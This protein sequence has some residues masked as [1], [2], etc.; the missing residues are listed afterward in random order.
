VPQQAEG[1]VDGGGDGRVGV[2]GQP[3]HGKVGRAGQ[4]GEPRLEQLHARD[5]TRDVA[6]HRPDGVEAG[7]QGPDPVEWDPSP[8]RL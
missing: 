8:G 1:A 7:R 6:G 4:D 5:E 2:D 3:R